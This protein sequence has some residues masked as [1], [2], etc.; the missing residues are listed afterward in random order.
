MWHEKVRAD[1]A[2]QRARRDTN[3]AQAPPSDLQ[4]DDASVDLDIGGLSHVAHLVV[5]HARPLRACIRR[6]ALHPLVVDRG[7]LRDELA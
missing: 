5:D 4:R 6:L 1:D 7:C 3:P 2:R